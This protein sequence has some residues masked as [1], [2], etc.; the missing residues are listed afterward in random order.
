MDPQVR[1]DWPELLSQQELAARLGVSRWTV[2]RWTQRQLI[3]GV[4]ELPGRVVRY[5][6]DQVLAWVRRREVRPA[7]DIIEVERDD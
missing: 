2:L 1:E 5:D 4:I 3:P 7:A 6:A